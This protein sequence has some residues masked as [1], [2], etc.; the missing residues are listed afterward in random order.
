M[1]TIR[2]NSQ[3]L[4]IY[5]DMARAKRAQRQLFPSGYANHPSVLPAPMKY[6]PSRSAMEF[7]PWQS[8]FHPRPMH[9]SGIPPNRT[10][11]LMGSTAPRDWRGWARTRGGK[12][13]RAM[14]REERVTGEGSFVPYV[15]S[16]SGPSYMEVRVLDFSTRSWRLQ[17][18]D[19]HFTYELAVGMSAG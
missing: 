1:S 16:R 3:E 4:R 5:R 10:S 2:S 18:K 15:Y 7:R 14:E 19:E 9:I 12:G 8:P 13:G 17:L 11:G 6:F